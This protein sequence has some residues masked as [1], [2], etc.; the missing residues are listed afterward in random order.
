VK[1]RP[2]AGLAAVTFSNNK[3]LYITPDIKIIRQLKQCE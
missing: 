2:G 1:K 3:T